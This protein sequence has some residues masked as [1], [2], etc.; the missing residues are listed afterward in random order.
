MKSIVIFLGIFLIGEA[1]GFIVPYPLKQINDSVRRVKREYNDGK[2]K[3][4]MLIRS[5]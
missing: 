3:F 2:R 1:Y 5:L 4:L